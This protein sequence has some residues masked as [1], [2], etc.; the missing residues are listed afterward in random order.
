MSPFRVLTTV[1]NGT[2]STKAKSTKLMAAMRSSKSDTD[3]S[4]I[5]IIERV[6]FPTNINDMKT[7]SHIMMN[8]KNSVILDEYRLVLEPNTK[9]RYTLY[10]DN[11]IVS[12][13]F[14]I[15]DGL[16][17]AMSDYCERK[18]LDIISIF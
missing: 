15:S 4:I 14:V 9:N 8:T 1:K 16:S 6:S 3:Y 18:S 12:T 13:E 7:L 17:S 10:H 5:Y 11:C 2:K